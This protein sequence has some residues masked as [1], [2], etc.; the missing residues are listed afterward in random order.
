ML[1]LPG[2]YHEPQKHVM[3]AYAPI[4]D[5]IGQ[6]EQFLAISSRPVTTHQIARA[7]GLSVRRIS[8]ICRVMFERGLII[9][10]EKPDHTMPKGF[11]WLIRRAE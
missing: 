5:R 4:E 11:K 6:V 7:V 1:N 8:Q 10:E 3:G 9:V 2:I